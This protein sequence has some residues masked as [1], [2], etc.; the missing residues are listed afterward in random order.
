E[1]VWPLDRWPDVSTRM[2]IGTRDRLFPPELQ[3]RVAGARLGL[4]PDEIDSGHLPALSRPAELT[5]LLLRYA[6]E[7]G[8]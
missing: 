4:V 5:A 3:R 2:V 8:L 7:T 6:E 1:D